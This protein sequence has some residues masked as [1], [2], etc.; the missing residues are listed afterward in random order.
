MKPINIPQENATETEFVG[1][2]SE[3]ALMSLRAIG[4]LEVASV[5]AS[6]FLTTWVMIP[7][8]PEPR[9]LIGAPGLFAIA[10]IVNSQRIRGER[11]H[12]L[13]L[14]GRNFGKALRLIA[15]PTL[16][17]AAVIAT[18]GYATNS[19]H[20][21]SHFWTNALF[22]PVW[23]ITQQFVLQAFIYRRVRGLL[24]AESASPD[25]QR[26]Q[27]RWAILA[28]AA[29]FSLAHL[30][31]LMLMVLTLIGGLMWSWVYERAPNLLALGLSHATLSFL[32]MTSAPD[33]LLPSL[34]VGYKHF[35]Y[36]KF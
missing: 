19:F 17:A 15:V 32:L 28:T 6:V 33:W 35:L 7:L 18:V 24:V 12:D 1:E 20:R 29:L 36:Q 5:L 8:Q 4:G 13:G 30:P 25:E 34:S 16:A 3:P 22:L 27:A 14:T 2:R 26:R 9:W 31:N 21:T 23:G 11:F 10:L